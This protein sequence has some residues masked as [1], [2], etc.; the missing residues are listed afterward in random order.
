LKVLEN[1]LEWLLKYITGDRV[2]KNSFL[3]KHRCTLLLP[4]CIL[5]SY[6]LVVLVS[7]PII[8]QYYLSLCHFVICTLLPNRLLLQSYQ[9]LIPTMVFLWFCKWYHRIF[10]ESYS[11]ADFRAKQIFLLWVWNRKTIA[12]PLVQQVCVKDNWI[13]QVMKNDR[14]IY[15]FYP[16]LQSDIQYNKTKF[17]L[18]ASFWGICLLCALILLR[19]LKLASIY[20]FHIVSQKDGSK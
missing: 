2:C 13:N 7:L 5:G 6:I 3:F 10:G 9:I 17:I 8:D 4:D 18:A 20:L 1:T 19:W 15:W 16:I 11:Y 14:N 12:T